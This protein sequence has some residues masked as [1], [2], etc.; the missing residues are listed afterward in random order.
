LNFWLMVIGFNLTFWPMHHLGLRGMTRRRYTYLPET[1]WQFLNV[2][3]TI[4]AFVIA[5]SV[6]V[7]I[8]N[9]IWSRRRGKLA[10]PN[11]WGAGTLEWA[12]SS[13]PPAYN[14]LHPPTCQGREPVWENPPDSP[15]VTGLSTTKREVLITTTL[16][17]APDHRYDLAGESIWPFLLA[18]AVAVT[19][20]VGGIFTPWGA[21]AGLFLAMLALFGWFW[22][23][24]KV[25]ERPAKL[26]ERRAALAAEGRAVR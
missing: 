5:A 4:G 23:S 18:C 16:D 12:T 3:A 11:P 17:A 26:A 7:F 15:V 22:T 19:L 13:P 21:P 24:R 9:V 14:F 8:V 1:G 25:K 2:L 6:A 10:G 20:L